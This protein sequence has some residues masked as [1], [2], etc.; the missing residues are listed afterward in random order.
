MITS[1]KCLV[2]GGSGFA[3]SHIINRL[4]ELKNNV[5]SIDIAEPSKEIKSKIDFKK[6]DIR[7]FDDVKKACKDVDHIFHNVA[8]VPIS[9]A[10]KLYDQVN[11]G[12][13]KNILQA[14]LENN[15]KSVVH[16][17]S[18]AVYKIPKKGDVISE[19]FTIEPVSSYGEAKYHAEEICFEYMKKGLSI[20]IIRPRTMLGADRLGIYSILFDWILNNK[21]VYILGDGSNKFSYISIKDLVEAIILC[22]E[23]GLGEIFNISTNVYGSYRSDLEELI[24]YAGS[25]SKIIPI[26]AS[27]CRTI[28][29]ILDK[30]NLSPLAEWHYKTV[31]KEYVFDISKAEK[32]LGWKPKDSNKKVFR[33]SYDWFK[34]NYH[35]LKKTGTTHTTK[36]DPKI[37]RIINR[38]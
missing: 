15:V 11:A 31:D 25:K 17:S 3:G 7:D 33:E 13:T 9:K 34:E 14:A 5:I 18:S 36:L 38:L 19:D 32:I 6:I 4:L 24:Q 10:D 37:F 26:N 22:T 27:F 1:K 20:S 12:G 35:S 16:L 8:L 23:K 29:K 21:K 28:L 2:T 30:I